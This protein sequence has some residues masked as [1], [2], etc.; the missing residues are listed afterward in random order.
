MMKWKKPISLL[1]LC[2]TLLAAISPITAEDDNVLYSWQPNDDKKIALTFDD[3]PHP[4]YTKEI[5]DILAEYDLKATFFVVGENAEWF[6][7]L[8]RREYEAG[9]EIGNHTYTH[10]NLRKAEYNSV[11][12]EILGAE[13]AVY[14]NTEFRCRLLRPP[15]GMYGD[16]VYKAAEN[17]DYTVVLW[18]VDT[19]D[20]AHT[21]SETIANEVL[22]NI[23]SGDIILFHDYIA[24]D[25]PTPEALRKIIPVLLAKDYHFVTVSELLGGA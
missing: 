7:E 15:G 8:V 18:S 9:H 23:K 3:G 6:P 20:W 16:N 11:L 5:L 1:V 21:P 17:L 12:D 22:S 13:D 24:S 14:E 10:A 25:S 4:V 2:V 19:R